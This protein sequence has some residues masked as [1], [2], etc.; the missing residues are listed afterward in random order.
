[1]ARVAV[2]GGS[3]ATLALRATLQAGTPIAATLSMGFRDPEERLVLLGAMRG[4]VNIE[5][6]QAE[7]VWDGLVWGLEVPG[8]EGPIVV[9]IYTSMQQ[10][11]S[12]AG[13]SDSDDSNRRRRHLLSHDYS[14]YGYSDYDNWWGSDYWYGDYYGDLEAE[15]RLAGVMELTAPVKYYGQLGAPV[16]RGFLSAEW[17]YDTDDVEMRLWVDTGAGLTEVPRGSV[18][19]AMIR[20]FLYERRTGLTG[21]VRLSR[22]KSSPVGSSV[23]PNSCSGGAV[24]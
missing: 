11:S 9:P 12:G 3:S 1:V 23:P 7:G 2:Q 19:G 16:M 15:R 22:F 6:T 17:A 8:S 4:A 18:P 10:Q 20:P 13:S 14:D 21:L 24:I 5:R